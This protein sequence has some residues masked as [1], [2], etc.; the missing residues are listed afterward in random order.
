MPRINELSSIYKKGIYLLSIEEILIRLQ[1]LDLPAR[2]KDFT[3]KVTQHY[4]EYNNRAG[5]DRLNRVYRYARKM[6][7]GV[8]FP[9]QQ[10]LEKLEKIFNQKTL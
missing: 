3:D 4:P 6:E 5:Y 9:T 7:G 1:N 10:E 8:T 2:A